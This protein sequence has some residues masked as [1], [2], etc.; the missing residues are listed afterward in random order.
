MKS[1]WLA[2]MVL[3]SVVVLSG[4]AQS[5][6]F[7]SYSDEV[8]S[9]SY[10]KR[11]GITVLDWFRDGTDIISPEIG[12]GE[13]FGINVQPTEL[14]QF[15]FLFGDVMKVGYRG[16]GAGFYQEIRKEGGLSY[17]Y[18]RNERFEPFV[19]T[20]ALFERERIFRGFPLRFN[21][22]WHWMDLGVEVGLIFGQVGVHVSPL[23]A[24]DF[25]ISTLMLPVNVVIRPPLGK[26]GVNLPI[27]DYGGD[28]TES[29]I[30]K[31]YEIEMPPYPEMFQPTEVINDLVKLPY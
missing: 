13:S 28:D 19:G 30:A 20:R 23:E 1:Y 10:P 17:A 3:L 7:T 2:G 5:R 11:V 18:Y 26:L 16:R 9:W 14:L 12:A 31:R 21:D 24:V 29:R 8:N 22:Q 15:G 25:A 4:C 6:A 27:V